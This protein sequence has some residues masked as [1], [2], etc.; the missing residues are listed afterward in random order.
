MNLIKHYITPSWYIYEQNITACVSVEKP[1]LLSAKAALTYLSLD[2]AVNKALR[3]SER[4]SHQERCID[5]QVW[6]P[7]QTLWRAL[8][9]ITLG[10]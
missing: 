2:V 8:F 1:Q 4:A 7:L 9:I 10:S 5:V 6:Q 3:V